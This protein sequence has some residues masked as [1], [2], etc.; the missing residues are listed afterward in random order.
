M[1]DV[2][3]SQGREIDVPRLSKLLG[4][5]VLPFVASQGKGMDELYAILENG[6]YQQYILQEDALKKEYETQ[7]GESFTELEEKLKPFRTDTYTSMWLV[8][9]LFEGDKEITESIK[10]TAEKKEWS[11]IQ[12]L[13][14]E[15]GRA[16]CRERV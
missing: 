7:I 8:T 3:K 12:K 13:Y 10:N 4:I 9:K 6:N 2:A 14:Y 15:I 11:K 16:S 5:P 1:I